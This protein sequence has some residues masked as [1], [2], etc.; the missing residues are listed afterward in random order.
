M[1]IFLFSN[2]FLLLIIIKML[3][4][5]LLQILLLLKMLIFWWLWQN[6]SSLDW[7]SFY[8]IFEDEIL[9]F[10][11][12][13]WFCHC[14][15]FKSFFSF[16]VFYF[17]FYEILS[18][19]EFKKSF[20]RSLWFH[21][22]FVFS[23]F[24]FFII[25]AVLFSLSRSEK[26]FDWIFLLILNSSKLSR[27]HL[28]FLHKQKSITIEEFLEDLKLKKNISSTK[29]YFFITFSESFLSFL[30]IKSS[31]RDK[32]LSQASIE[33]RVFIKMF[34]KRSTF[35][36][37]EKNFEFNDIVAKKWFLKFDYEMSAY[38]DKMT[39]STTATNE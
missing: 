30:R 36:I 5:Y 22:N 25:S 7:S 28:D 20:S 15:F 35:E 24:Q 34:A 9:E 3:S 14:L 4:I 39:P 12:F 18:L 32:L 26:I 10:F 11:S 16:W 8:L 38:C 27:S 37:C 2:S 17:L 13:E 29:D 6:V 19:Y 33:R 23:S 31:S 21:F 1:K